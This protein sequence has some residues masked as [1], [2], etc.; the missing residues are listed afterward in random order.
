[1]S[2]SFVIVHKYVVKA[3][4]ISHAKS[5]I[6]GEDGFGEIL[7]DNSEIKEVSEKEAIDVIN[8]K[9]TV[10]SADVLHLSEY[11][12]EPESDLSYVDSEENFGEALNQSRNDFLRSENKRLIKLIEKYKNIRS[13]TRISAYQ[14]AYDAFSSFELPKI[15][16][17]T[18]K[19]NKEKLA[20]TAVVVF[21]DWQLG[22]GNSKLQ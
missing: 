18:F 16:K 2:K 12:E 15:Q 21:S 7:S 14:A 4:N 22:K 1:M 8:S 6:T 13:E 3:P 20:E 17:P 10:Y 19:K 9:D 5:L 11:R